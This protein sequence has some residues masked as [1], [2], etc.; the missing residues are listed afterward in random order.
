MSWIRKAQD[1][2]LFTSH[3]LHGLSGFFAGV[4]EILD[5]SPLAGFAS[6]ARPSDTIPSP[7]DEEADAVGF[8][9]VSPQGL[10]MVAPPRKETKSVVEEPLVGSIAARKRTL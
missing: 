9:G 6:E 10:D 2:A 8:Q 1:A 3:F 4:A 5:S 7:A